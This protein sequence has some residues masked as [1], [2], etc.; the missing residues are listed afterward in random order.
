[1]TTKAVITSGK[2]KTAIARSTVTK[3]T[4]KVRINKQPID[5]YQPEFARLKI[6]ELLE[7]SGAIISDIDINVNVKGGG[8]MGQAN[9]ARTA[10]A[11]G[12]I[13]WTNDTNLK[14]LFMAHDRQLLVN[15]SRKKESKK[16]GG[17]GAR[18]KYQK[19]YR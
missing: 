11:R 16:F 13:D 9:A 18:A 3:G 17:P 10:I 1:M 6:E 7:M 12:I 2:S 5:I 15:D 8:I 4:G 14:D 19:S